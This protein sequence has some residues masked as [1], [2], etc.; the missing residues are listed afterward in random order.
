MFLT[1]L[2]LLIPAFSLLCSPA[3]L[4]VCLLPA[5][6][7]PLPSPAMISIIIMLL[8]WL[9][10]AIHTLII[11]IIAGNPP[12]RCHVLAPDIFGASSLDQ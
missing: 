10:V 3:V 4:S 5:H 9:E 2:S 7:A 1:W 12:L 8:L 11:E 6:Y